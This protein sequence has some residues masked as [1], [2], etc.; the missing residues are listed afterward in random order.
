MAP[1]KRGVG[2]FGKLQ[3]N[4]EYV[5]VCEVLWVEGKAP[6]MGPYLPIKIVYPTSAVSP[7]FYG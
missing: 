2:E 5:G 4:G 6:H 3:V 1:L 7:N